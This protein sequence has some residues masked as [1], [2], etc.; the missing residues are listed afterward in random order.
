MWRQH[1]AASV[2]RSPHQHHPVFRRSSPSSFSSMSISHASVVPRRFLSVTP[3]SL[4]QQTA[5]Q[6]GG[7]P[8]EPLRPPSPASL[9]APRPARDFRRTRAWTR[10]TL[11]VGAMFGVGYLVDKTVYASG[12]ARSL[13][14]FGTGLL[15]AV[16]YKM[17]FRPKPLPW[18]GNQEG[19]PGLHRRSAERLSDL[20]HRNGG[21]YLKIGQAI[22]MQSAVLP[23]EFQK[24]FARMFDD[25]PQDE[26]HAVE[27]VIQEDFGGRSVE[28]VFGVSFAGVE[29]KGVME[30][31][32]RA[33]ASVAQV[34]WAR[35]PDGREVAVKI[36]KPEIE[37][38][39]GWDLWAFQVTMW[40]YTWWFDLPMYSMVPFVM[41]RLQLETDFEN[42][43]KNSEIMRKLVNAE[44]KLQG[45][46][47]IPPVYYE[48][49]S[50][51][52][53]TTEW[54]EGVRF[55]DTDVLT[56]P[57]RGGYGS[58]SIGVHGEQLPPPDMAALRR[59]MRENPNSQ[60]L[61]PARDD[62]K[63]RHQTG[64]L[65]VSATDV[66]QTMVDLFSAQIFK[67]GVVHCDPHPGNMFVRRLPNGKPELVLI[68][69]GL[70]VF[71]S[72][73]FR[74]EY[75]E[76]WK[77]LMTFDNNKIT[78]ISE[79]WGIKGAELFASATLMRPYEGGEGR[80]QKG[81]LTTRS[82]YE[83]QQ[84]MKQAMRDMLADEEKWPKELIFI[85]RNMRIVQGNNA[86]LGSP[87]NR[88][89]IMGEWSS[90][91]LF[92]DPNLPWR[93]RAT[94]AWRHVLWK[95]VLLL[96]DVLFWFYRIK[97]LL[98]RSK[99][100]EDEVEERFREVAKE[101]GIELQHDVFAG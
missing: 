37:K 86:F 33:S 92:Q 52:V 62:W 11:L 14:T 24:M 13:R 27:K 12:I 71:L 30:R 42:E 65:G 64:G 16:D 73:K 10:Y 17:N 7:G 8:F 60:M 23:P 3:P 36:Q 96:S 47:Y 78:D 90:R 28:E 58:G 84:K 72:D 22:A 61:K 6:G 91:A 95:G 75:A 9:G 21:L 5:V 34:H 57:W 99:G 53:L 93:Q 50:K 45:R 31:T 41:E 77:A 44:P 56:K 46:V 80:L 26:W 40:V 74:H 87:V 69:H 39:I 97:Q 38:Q 76:F 67:F 82:H 25:A 55:R 49:S 48:L 79:S 59:E 43:A 29:G 85:S 32:A 98:G 2:R 20:L 83:M 51:R 18:I 35:L 88:I 89:K 66:M 68:D 15:V 101:Y 94:Y 63:G 54:I 81:L 4:Q 19:I 70:Y 100:M 1:L